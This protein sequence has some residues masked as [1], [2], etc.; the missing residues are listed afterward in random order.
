MSR[1]KKSGELSNESTEQNSHQNHQNNNRILNN[2]NNTNNQPKHRRKANR[3]EVHRSIKQQDLH[4]LSDCNFVDFNTPFD[5]LIALAKQHLAKSK[6]NSSSDRHPHH[7][8]H[9]A[10]LEKNQSKKKIEV[11][12]Q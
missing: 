7:H 11:K 5:D 10:L 6:L 12:Y 2:N 9:F 3:W 8:L 1:Q 4:L